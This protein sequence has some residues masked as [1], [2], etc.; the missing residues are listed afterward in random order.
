ME[1]LAPAPQ[2]QPEVVFTGCTGLLGHYLLDTLAARPSIRK[3]I[4]VTVRKLLERL[5]T[6]TPPPSSDR[7]VYYKGDLTQPRFSLTNDTWAG[8][9]NSSDT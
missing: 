9:F 7:I 1:T 2:R 6:K 3:I 8:I 4:C 5:Q